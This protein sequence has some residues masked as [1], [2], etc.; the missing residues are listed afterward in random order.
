MRKRPHIQTKQLLSALMTLLLLAGNGV[1]ASDFTTADISPKSLSGGGTTVFDTSKNAFTLSARNLQQDRK[2]LF[3]TGNSF[4]NEN[5]VAAPSSTAGRDGLGPLFIARSC[6]ACHFKDGRDHAP[7]E[8]ELSK[9]LVF[10]LSLPGKDKQTG[11]PIPEPTYGGQ[12]QTRALPGVMPES[13]VQMHWVETT[14]HYAD[15]DVYPLRRPN[16]VFTNAAYGPMKATMRFSVRVA[17]AVIGLG[18]LEAVPEETLAKLADPD[19]KDGDGISGKMNRVWDVM[20]QKKTVGRFGWKAEQPVVRQQVAGAFN[21][22]MGLTTSLFLHEN[23]SEA[24]ASQIQ[25]TSG[26]SPEVSEE[27]L[28]AVV[29]YSRTLAVPARRGVEAPEVVRGEKLFRDIGCAACHVP[30][31]KTAASFDL[32]ELANQTIQPFTDLLLH[33]MG[34][35]LADGREVFEASGQEWRT[36]PLWGIGLVKTVNGH[37]EFLHDGRA[38]NLAEAI[39]WHGGEAKKSNERFRALSK[40]EREALLRFLE[41]L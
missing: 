23:H 41:S 10:R 1:H 39:L 24:Q 40:T 5:W 36:P 6:S 9:T 34:D 38:R 30:E 20:A 4:F 33:D 31:L 22:D 18:L 7:A 25:F 17:P 14:G 37:T 3:F 19:D 27:I 15:G 8:G 16:Y 26:G 21:D 13:D 35:G 12:L 29:L 28:N 32:P 2:A 11:G